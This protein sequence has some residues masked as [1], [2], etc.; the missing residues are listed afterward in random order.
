[1][2]RKQGL[3]L[4]F[5]Y[6]FIVS[7]CAQLLYLIDIPDFRI[8]SVLSIAGITFVIL[9]ILMV[10]PKANWLFLLALT[11]LALQVLYTR[12][13]IQV[14]TF[15][16]LE[17]IIYEV[18]R[19]TITLN[20]AKPLMVEHFYIVFIPIVTIVGFILF[21]GLKSTLTSIVLLT[22]PLFFVNTNLFKFEWE[23]LYFVG[24][25]A[26]TVWL[27]KEKAP[28]LL[29]V[30]VLLGLLIS[31]S[32]YRP[33]DLFYNDQ[34]AQWLT[35]LDVLSLGEKQEGFSLDEV[36]FSA[37]DTRIGGPVELTNTPYM[38]VWGPSESFY[39]RGS[40]FESFKDNKWTRSSMDNVFVFDQQAHS[41]G[42]L[43]ELT[44]NTQARLN[45][46]NTEDVFSQNDLRIRPIARSFSTI[47]TAGTPIQLLFDYQN[48]QESDQ[49]VWN[50][51]GQ[52][53]S[54]KLIDNSGYLINDLVTPTRNLSLPLFFNLPVTLAK[55]TEAVPNQY[56]SLVAAYDPTLHSL[57]YQRTDFSSDMVWIQ[58]ILNHFSLAY[59]YSLE[60]AD[61]PFEDSVIEWFLQNKIGYCVY[62]GTL[63]TLL[64]E[65]V[66]YQARYVEGFVVPAS[67]DFDEEF[68]SYERV[69]TSDTAHAWT[70]VY[71][72][73]LGWYPIDP[74]TP[75]HLLALDNGNPQP[76]LP[77]DEEIPIDDD[78]IIDP[79]DP[80]D[81][82]DDQ[83]STPDKRNQSLLTW[84]IGWT[85][86]LGVLGFS[87]F[88]IVKRIRIRQN[89]SL[90]MKRFKDRERFLVRYV[91]HD[92]LFVNRKQITQNQ[93]I[94][95]VFRLF[96][97]ENKGVQA[98][99]EKS[100][101][102]H[103]L[104]SP[105]EA[106]Q[107]LEYYRQFV[108]SK[109]QSIFTRLKTNEFT[110]RWVNR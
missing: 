61:I 90:L 82:N 59:G 24:L 50:L 67:D 81:P 6:F 70:E 58:S 89:N 22:T 34:L 11:Y 110:S 1:M 102:S 39:L 25:I 97:S 45:Y 30:A 105:I 49:F 57:V 47:F 7:L 26:S 32:I 4:V 14:W 27:N 28:S 29:T 44:F 79:P 62:Y 46:L 35:D 33:T 87:F 94:G 53:A 64:L 43:Y 106:K 41:Q 93:S 109:N 13:T 38:R 96:A 69:V 108:I 60:V 91:W 10:F 92:L 86:S 52:L 72:E 99:I 78:D 18:G 16:G 9:A 88:R 37:S 40:V 71:I 19:W 54:I 107:V 65:D 77:E 15:Y 12:Y 51:E 20:S 5:G 2:D 63:M 76:T 8:F 55:D 73:G 103:Q 3:Q 83:P 75:G 104:V 95:D 42:N 84:A 80:I 36:G 21:Y 101:H 48:P 100:I 98:I 17:K 68:D 66:G 31:S 56:S 85:L 74:T 23:L